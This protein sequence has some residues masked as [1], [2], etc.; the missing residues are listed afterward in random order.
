MMPEH[1]L[2]QPPRVLSQAQRED[3]WAKGYLLVERAIPPDWIER[4]RTVTAEMVERSR[5]QTHS[6]AIFDLEPNHSAAQPRLRRLSSPVVHHPL[7]WEFL[8]QSPLGDIA[9]DLVGPDVRFHHQKLNFKWAE[10]GEE[11]KWH[12]DIQFF[13]HTNYNVLTIGVYLYDCGPDQGPL[14]V[15]PGSHKGAIYNQY[16]ARDQWAGCLSDDDAAGLDLSKA[17]YLEGPAGSIT[18]HHCR[19]VHGSKPNLSDTGRPLLLQT[20]SS[21]DAFPFTHNPLTTRYY[22]ECIRGK[23]ARVPHMDPFPCP[24]PPD[25]SGGYKPM[26]FAGQDED[27]VD[28]SALAAELRAQRTTEPAPVM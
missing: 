13:P 5:Q 20:L 27:A 24:V 4:L 6:D 23:P 25:W 2:A 15:M 7:Y 22:G 19:T 3:Y 11:V 10:G 14:G 17:A 1:V 16:N 26:F 28:A 12:Q 18:I 8:T 9:A 21:A